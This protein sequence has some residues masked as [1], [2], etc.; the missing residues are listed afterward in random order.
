VHA[1]G[2]EAAI[3]WHPHTLSTD[4]GWQSGFQEMLEMAGAR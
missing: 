1:V 4:Y 2:G 3:L